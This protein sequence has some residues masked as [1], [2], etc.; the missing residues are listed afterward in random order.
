M[1]AAGEMEWGRNANAEFRTVC[2]RLK[3]GRSEGIG[4]VRRVYRHL[5]LEEPV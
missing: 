2:E 5:G 4:M 3:L 1:A